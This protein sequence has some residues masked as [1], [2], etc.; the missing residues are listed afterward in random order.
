[1]KKKSFIKDLLSVFTSRAATLLL[2]L[3]GSIIT[4]RYL[5][6]E[7]NGVIAAV[8]VYPS[9][10]M[11]IGALGI[12]QS[13][14]YFIGQGKYQLSEVYGA[15]LAILLFTS[16][17]CLLS[18]YLL[19]HDFT[20]AKYK[21]ALIFW[22]IAGIPFSLYTT[23]SAGIFLGMQ[24]I[25]EFNK[26]NW[27]PSAINVVFTFIFIAIFPFGT[28][29]SMAGTFMGVFLMSFMVYFMI[30]KYVAVKPKFDFVI[31]KQLLS[32]G[33]IY[34]VTAMITILNY[35]VDIVLLEKWSNTYQLGIYS[36]GA[37]LVELLWQIPTILSTITFS[38]SAAAKDSHAF[39]LKVCSLLRF[40]GILIIILS[41]GF[42]FTAP[43][44]IVL[45]YGKAFYGSIAVIRILLPGVILMTIY[46]ILYQ[47]IAGRGKP[48]KSM[49]AML[50]TMILNIVLNYYWI[51]K[52]GANGSA[53]ASSVS[54]SIS[55]I[56]FI[57]VYSRYTAIPL[58]TMLSFSSEDKELFS[59]LMSKIKRTPQLKN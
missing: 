17:I 2:G 24:K 3:L 16:V 47:D 15:V 28:A 49:E 58:K 21:N 32:L 26:I 50:P 23:Y 12:Q 25:K 51:P 53:M 44:I 20:H 46:K 40:T 10:F 30:R 11:T 38:R 45:M 36:K 56:I 42:Y 6:P 27:I 34:A 8:T 5:G 7:G 52:Y 19:I 48:W 9:L 43:W 54:Y 35:K 57:F 41:I 39:S 22:A 1:L 31:I 59:K 13:T 14:T 4:A 33:L 18:C 37:I 29:G 55:A